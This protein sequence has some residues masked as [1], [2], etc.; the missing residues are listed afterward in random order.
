MKRRQFLA[1]TAGTL[2]LAGSSGLPVLASML[3][4]VQVFNNPNCGCCSAW[5]THLKQSGFTV[6]VTEVNDT[7]V[8][9]RQHGMPDKY[10]SCHTATV[11]GYVIEGH[12]PAKDIKRLLTSRI[13]ALGLAVPG[14]PVGSPGMEVGAQQDAYQVLLIDKHGRDRVFASYPQISRS[15][16]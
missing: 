2:A 8:A 4:V 12:V 14:M 5:V 6:K 1:G 3:P 11:A 16:P 7:A 9:R 13:T 10:G 15:K